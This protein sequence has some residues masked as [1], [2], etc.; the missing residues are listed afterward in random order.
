M[1]HPLLQLFI[2]T[3]MSGAGKTV[4]MQ[5]LEDAGFYC[6]DNLPPQ[7]IPKLSVLLEHTGNHIQKVALAIDLRTL[8][9]FEALPKALQEIK[10][11]HQLDYQMVFLDAG[12]ETLV[13]R[14][15]QSRRK[16]PL[17]TTDSPLSGIQS[18]RM[19]LKDL[20]QSAHLTID[21]SNFKPIQ[22]KE[23]IVHLLTKKETDMLV[24]MM[25]FGF[26]YGIPLDAD[27]VFD[28]RFLPN[29][30]YVPELRPKNG[31]QKEVADYVFQGGK[32]QS[33]FEKLLDFLSFSLPR[34]KEE[35]KQQLVV[36]IGCTGGKHRSVALT[37]KIG[38]ALALNYNTYINHRD[39]G[40]E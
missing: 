5:S 7:L 40:R 27:L 6:I 8:D 20:H 35:G 21:T 29:P 14:Y 15:K 12:D 19:L 17:A 18:E 11:V 39:L 32:G 3:G 10:H 37:E 30:Y 34:Y 38:K 25:S 13:Q 26:K 23:K 31:Q 22:L 4:A 9:F 16:H 2:V 36:A 24:N 28:V 1:A 33:Y